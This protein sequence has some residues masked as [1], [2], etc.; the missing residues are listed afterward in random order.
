MLG[1]RLEKANRIAE[2][3]YRRQNQLWV[4]EVYGGIANVPQ[5]MLDYI[6]FNPKKM[7]G[8]LRKTRA[9]YK[10]RKRE[11]FGRTRQERRADISY[12]EQLQEVYK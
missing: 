1:K 11:D 10:N 9:F 4:Y 7:I 12:H 3:A 6:G 8:M 2:R 5:H